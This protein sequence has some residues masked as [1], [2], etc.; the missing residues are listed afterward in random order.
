MIERRRAAK[1][2]LAASLALPGAGAATGCGGGTHDVVPESRDVR[3]AAA[4]GVVSGEGYEYVA[5]RGLGTVALA[6][7]RGIAPEI[8]VAAT[9]RLADALQSCAAEAQRQ[10]QLARGA[11]RVVAHV[12]DNGAIDAIQI[13][14]SPGRRVAANAILCVIAPVRLL[15]FPPRSAGS[16]ADDAGARKDR[17]IAIEATWEGEDEPSP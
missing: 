14:V 13:K 1:A 11:A 12:N 8:G 2:L 7:A 6:E 16:E 5:R 15:T 10:R 9:E 3:G 4:M 17:G